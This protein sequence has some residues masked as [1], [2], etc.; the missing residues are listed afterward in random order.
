MLYIPYSLKRC[1]KCG[2]WKLDSA[3]YFFV[4]K[5]GK[6]TLL[7]RCK[8]CNRIATVESKEYNESRLAKPQHKSGI[9]YMPQSMKRCIWCDEWKLDSLIWFGRESESRRLR[10]ICK[11]CIN[12]DKN[13]HRQNHIKHLT[14]QDREA[15]LESRRKYREANRQRICLQSRAYYQANKEAIRVKDIANRDYRLAKK[16]QHYQRNAEVLRA[17]SRAY[18]KANRAKIREWWHRLKAENPEKYAAL[19][20][21]GRN[22]RRARKLAAGGTHTTQDIK[23]Q[24]AAQEGRCYYCQAEVGAKYHVDHFIPLSKGGSNDPS[25]IVIA[26][27]S[28]NL[29]K[30]NK[31]PD[32]FAEFLRIEK[33]KHP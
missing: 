5:K 15:Y 25:N 21:A 26:C 16:R 4:L 11:S 23:N 6:P 17:E 27:P 20:R 10:T 31:T 19:V 2:E 24:Y 8:P 7:A 9:V 14:G 1:T 3:K 29:R 12:K 22:N 33:E 18:R 28:C 30:N 13:L 32:E